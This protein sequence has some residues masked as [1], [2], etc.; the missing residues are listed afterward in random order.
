VPAD[1]SQPVVY[2]R[3]AVNVDGL[4]VGEEGEVELSPR[5]EKM[6]KSGY[7]QII[8]HVL[9]PAAP[10]WLPPAYDGIPSPDPAPGFVAAPVANPT[11][12]RAVVKESDGPESPHPA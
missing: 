8:G 1:E 4:R 3:V 7:L 12:S 5:I 10:Q 6:I 11:R 9:P 2:V